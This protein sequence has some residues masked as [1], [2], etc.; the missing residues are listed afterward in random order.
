MRFFKCNFE[1]ENIIKRYSTTEEVLKAISELNLMI[2]KLII[3]LD[4][5]TKKIEN[6]FGFVN[7]KKDPITNKII[8]PEINSIYKFNEKKFKREEDHIFI[9]IIG[10]EYIDVDNPCFDFST[11]CAKVV[12]YFINKKHNTD[13]DVSLN[14]MK[15][16]DIQ[17]DILDTSIYEITDKKGF[18]N[19]I[20][21]LKNV[22]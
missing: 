16:L 20:S 10:Y 5:D 14:Y 6:Y 11:I 22:L 18:E 7:F 4:L 21:E 8:I 15:L 13:I 19:L 1:K 12:S 3:S 17:R 9:K 2:D